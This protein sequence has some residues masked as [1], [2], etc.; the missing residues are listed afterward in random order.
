MEGDEYGVNAIHRL[1]P[2]ELG[3][4]KFSGVEDGVS[5]EGEKALTLHCQLNRCD[6]WKKKCFEKA[7]RSGS[8]GRKGPVFIKRGKG[9]NSHQGCHFVFA[10]DTDALEFLSFSLCLFSK[11]K[12]KKGPQV[13]LSIVTK[14]E[15]SEK[16]VFIIFSFCLLGI[17]LLYWSS[18]Q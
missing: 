12:K 16:D 17:L 3:N 5:D 10:D 8:Q 11:K 14:S 9:V 15:T 13:L 7:I 2:S 18:P 4:L 1:A 6:R